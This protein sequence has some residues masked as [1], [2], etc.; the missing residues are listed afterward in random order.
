MRNTGDK[1]VTIYQV[2]F[3][4]IIGILRIF[5]LDT[6]KLITHT[7]LKMKVIVYNQDS[8]HCF[9]SNC[10]ADIISVKVL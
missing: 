4:K 9:Y 10:Y 3:I 7:F 2:L 6:S 1:V 5:F 8:T